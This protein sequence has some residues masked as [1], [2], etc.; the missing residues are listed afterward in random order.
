[1]TF[2]FPIFFVGG[3]KTLVRDSEFSK[4][5]ELNRIDHPPM[6]PTNASLARL[7]AGSAE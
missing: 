7:A 2:S 3:F 1:L 5:L 4:Y 6:N